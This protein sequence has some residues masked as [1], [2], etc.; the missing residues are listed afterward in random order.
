MEAAGHS[1]SSV[2][3]I[4]LHDAV[5]P[6]DLSQYK[7]YFTLIIVTYMNDGIKVDSVNRHQIMKVY[8]V[9]WRR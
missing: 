6:E 5:I 3:Y 7:C 2:V 4:S 1:W 8:K 9:R